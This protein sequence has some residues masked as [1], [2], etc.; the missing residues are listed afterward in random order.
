MAK[1]NVSLVTPHRQV[2]GAQVD[3]VTAPSV[4]G[5]VGILPD[6]LPLL[7]DLTEGPVGLYRG[8]VV[9]MYAISG[10][11]LEV[12][13]N[14]VLLLAETAE[15]A[16]EIDRARSEAALKDA[17]RKL[18]I[19]AIDDPDYPKQE[20]RARRNRVRLEIASRS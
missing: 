14:E 17:E 1:L 20:A 15:R 4:M 3:Q 19:L 18:Q 6:H 5:E 11:F 13:D 9:D 2:V 12:N 7:A 10:G 16:D 8:G